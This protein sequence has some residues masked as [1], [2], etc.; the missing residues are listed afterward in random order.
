MIITYNPGC[1]CR[2]YTEFY[3][4]GVIFAERTFK[5]TDKGEYI[6]GE[7]KNLFHNGKIK[8]YKFWKNTL[9]FGRAYSNY[10]NGQL[11]HEEF[12]EGKYKSGIWKY[13]DPSGNLVKEI[14]YPP[15]TTLWNSKKDIATMRRYANGKMIATEAMTGKSTVAKRKDTLFNLAAITDGQKLFTLRCAACHAFDK[16]GYGPM[17]KGITKKRDNYWLSRWITDASNLIAD[18]DRDAISIAKKW[19]NKKHLSEN[20]SKEQMAALIGYIK[21]LD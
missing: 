19:N 4:D 5:V 13:F 10:E 8:D 7:D 20:F 3:T 18:G 1:S 15:N 2:T 21:K 12:Y 16:D 14:I 11:E 9:P 6:D 17:L